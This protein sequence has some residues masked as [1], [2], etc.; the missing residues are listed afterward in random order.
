[1]SGRVLEGPGRVLGV[2]LGAR[3]GQGGQPGM[4]RMARPEAS[5]PDR[6]IELS[7]PSQTS[8]A[9]AKTENPGDSGLEGQIGVFEPGAFNLGFWHPRGEI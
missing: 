2:I 7:D 1:M 9:F 8:N 4:A 5:W 6:Q 3:D